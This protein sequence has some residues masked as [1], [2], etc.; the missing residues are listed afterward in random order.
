MKNPNLTD[1]QVT[2]LAQK[3]QVKVDPDNATEY[4]LCLVIHALERELEKQGIALPKT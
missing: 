3:Y 1:E 4:K 2:L